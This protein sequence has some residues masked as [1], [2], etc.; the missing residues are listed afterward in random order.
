MNT[1][2]LLAAAKRDVD[3]VAFLVARG[4]TV[5]EGNSAHWRQVDG[6]G[7]ERLLV[8]RSLAGEWLW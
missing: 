6:P 5:N 8:H 4:W 2:E 7:G 3:L 1:Q